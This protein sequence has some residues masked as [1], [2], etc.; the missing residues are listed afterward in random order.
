M[1]TRRELVFL[2]AVRA[3]LAFGPRTPAA[4]SALQCRGKNLVR[5]IKHD[6]DTKEKKK[7]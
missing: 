4:H 7:S 2:S 6:E 3:A 1:M 5:N